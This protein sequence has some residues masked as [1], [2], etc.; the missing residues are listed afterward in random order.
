[1]TDTNKRCQTVKEKT[2][3]TCNEPH[4]PNHHHKHEPNCGHTAIGHDG[5]VDYLHD[6]HLHHMHIDHVDACQQDKPVAMHAGRAMFGAYA[7]PW[8]RSRSC[9]AQ[10]PRRLPRERTAASSARRSLR[11]PWGRSVGLAGVIAAETRRQK[12]VGYSQSS[13]ENRRPCQSMDLAPELARS[14]IRYSVAK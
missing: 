5:H 10:R 3:A 7:R 2:M 14:S 13:R 4:H 1:M 11:R 9:P 12:E 6:G 8:V